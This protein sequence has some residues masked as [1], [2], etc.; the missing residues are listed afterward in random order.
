MAGLFYANFSFMTNSE[1]KTIELIVE[2]LTS[3]L[4]NMPADQ[5]D[6][7][8][9]NAVNKIYNDL[10]NK[11]GKLVFHGS[12]ICYGIAR[13]GRPCCEWTGEYKFIED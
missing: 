4:G 5:A 12:H 13:N 7:V 2:K 8:V 11:Q 3:T 9:K 1:I 10:L 6:R